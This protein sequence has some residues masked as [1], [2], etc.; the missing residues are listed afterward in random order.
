MLRIE[1]LNIEQLKLYE[2][3]AKRHPREQVEEIQ[4]SIVMYGMNDPIGV[5]GPENVIVEGHGRYMACK[6]LGPELSCLSFIRIGI[7]ATCST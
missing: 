4:Q 7:M 3:N 1:Y 2:G 6:A 5:W